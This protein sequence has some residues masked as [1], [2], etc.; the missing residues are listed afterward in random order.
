MKLKCPA[1]KKAVEA[2]DPNGPSPDGL[3]QVKCP[4][5]E[6]TSDHPN[7]HGDESYTFTETTWL[8][9]IVE[10]VAG[11]RARDGSGPAQVRVLTGYELADVGEVG[12]VEFNPGQAIQRR[13]APA[14]LLEEVSE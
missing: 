2:T 5:C 14:E 1:C 11:A 9:P 3:V 12:A 8:R 6:V 10:K 4:H 7:P 13:L